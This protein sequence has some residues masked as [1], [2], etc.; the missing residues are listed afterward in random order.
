VCAAG[1]AERPDVV[2]VESDLPLHMEMEIVS[3]VL[4]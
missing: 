4:G 3:I 1:P 2:G